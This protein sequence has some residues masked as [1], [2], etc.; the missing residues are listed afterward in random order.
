MGGG[1]RFYNRLNLDIDS[2]GNDNG[3][4]YDANPQ[5]GHVLINI[6]NTDQASTNIIA[7]FMCKENS[8]P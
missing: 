6:W 8:T 4:T 1:T 7:L 3:R 2:N 5:H